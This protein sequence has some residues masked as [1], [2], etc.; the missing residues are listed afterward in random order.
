MLLWKILGTQYH[1]CWL[2]L[3]VYGVCLRAHFVL[4]AYLLYSVLG[5][6]SREQ[7]LS[8]EHPDLGT[9]L[10]LIVENGQKV[11]LVTSLVFL[12]AI[13]ILR[14]DH[15]ELLVEALLFLFK[16]EGTEHVF[17]FAVV[18]HRL[19]VELFDLDAKILQVF[20]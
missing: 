15:V 20:G 11:A 16:D 1:I 14:V 3:P 9:R 2:L 10:L 17:Y 5:E 8:I 4:I 18:G 12:I 6:N 19:K 7:M 13:E